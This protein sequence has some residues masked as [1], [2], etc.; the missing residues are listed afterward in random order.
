MTTLRVAN[1]LASVMVPI[2]IVGAALATVCAIV[3][4][5][6][7]V[8]GAGGLSGGAV[9]LWIVCALM[10]FM[11]SFANQWMPLLVA[12]AVLVAM[13]VLGGVVRAILNATEVGREARRRE[14]AEA[15]VPARRVVSTVSSVP[16]VSTKTGSVSI[17]S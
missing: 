7:I 17:V 13:L 11:A 1:D 2:G 3:A 6:A 10:S 15:P 16:T 14:R 9:G 5:V 4:A 8:R 12:C